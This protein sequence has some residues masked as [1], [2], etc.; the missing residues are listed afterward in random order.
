MTTPERAAALKQSAAQA[1]PKTWQT[2]VFPDA[3]TFANFLNVAPAQVAGEAFA[4]NRADGQVDGYF[5]L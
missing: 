4:S 2:S 1:T 5:F 3:T